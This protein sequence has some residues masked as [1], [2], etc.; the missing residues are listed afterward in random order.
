MARAR[1]NHQLLVASF[2]LF[3][4]VLAEVAAVGVLAVDDKHRA[5]DFV[6]IGEQLCVQERCCGL[7]RPAAVRVERAF[8]VAARRLVVGVV[9]LDELGRVL[10]KRIDDS[11]CERVCSCGEVLGALCRKRAAEVLPGLRAV[12]RVEVAVRGVAGEVVHCGGDRSLDSRVDCR[13]VDRHAAPAA[14]SD[15][16]DFLRV[17]VLLDGKEVNRRLKVLGVDVGRIH[18][19]R[20]AAAFARE[21]RVERQ[22]D[23][24]A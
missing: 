12:V 16:A 3:E 8:M 21:R 11:A 10:G 13:R 19:P 17:D 5:F 1:D 7:H 4:R 9:V 22:R 2:Q 6:G 15:D 20:L 24:S 23:K 18:V 14:D